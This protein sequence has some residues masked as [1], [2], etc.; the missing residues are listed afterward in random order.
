[1]DGSWISLIIALIALLI[2][3]S[4]SAITLKNQARLLGKLKEGDKEQLVNTLISDAR[5]LRITAWVLVIG[6]SI[7]ILV[8]TVKSICN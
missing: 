8:F 4:T 7:L 3:L 2:S 5:F 1:M 6:I